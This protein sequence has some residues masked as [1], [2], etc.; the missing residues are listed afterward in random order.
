M[1]SLGLQKSDYPANTNST[2]IKKLSKIFQAKSS[3]VRSCPTLSSMK[4]IGNIS[5]KYY[6][7]V[8]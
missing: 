3:R 2:T 8:I 4:V 1:P 7:E 5:K 6:T